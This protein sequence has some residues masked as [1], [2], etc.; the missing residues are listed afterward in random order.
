MSLSIKE[1]DEFAEITTVMEIGE[2]LRW[3]IRVGWY[4]HTDGRMCERPMDQL[5][6]QRL[7][8]VTNATYALLVSALGGL[9]SVEDVFVWPDAD[10][11]AVRKAARLMNSRL[12]H[13]D[14]HQPATCPTTGARQASAD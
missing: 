7:I 13:K 2:P 4:F 1:L 9:H 3:K 6:L 14:R 8:F 11:A 5:S 10:L 12:G